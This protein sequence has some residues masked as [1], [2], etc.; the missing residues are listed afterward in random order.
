MRKEGYISEEMHD[1]LGYPQDY[2]EGKYDVNCH[3]CAEQ[4]HMQRVKP[5]MRDVQISLCNEYKEGKKRKGK[6]GERNVR[7]NY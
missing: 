3:V 6:K 7:S 2:E 5:L 1:H 4:E